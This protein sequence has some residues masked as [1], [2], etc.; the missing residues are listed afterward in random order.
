MKTIPFDI[1]KAKSGKY[2]IQNKDGKPVRIIEWNRKSENGLTPIVGLINYGDF[3]SPY[4]YTKEGKATIYNE[5]HYHD[6][7]LVDEST[8]NIGKRIFDIITKKCN[9]YPSLK[10]ITPISAAVLSDFIQEELNLPKWK[11]IYKGERLPE[12]S[13]TKS[14]FHSQS[15][16]PCM[17][18]VEIG[19]DCWY[20]PVTVLN[21]LENE[22]LFNTY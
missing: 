3:E 17:K 1:E 8:P 20:L 16:M 4:T 9:D 6:L 12:T 22:E 13:Y 2:K 21:E 15:Y 7:V 5:E 11:R 10:H 18:G 19:S 14:D